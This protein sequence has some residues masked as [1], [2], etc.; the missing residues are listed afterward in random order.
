MTENERNPML[1]RLQKM[2]DEIE[3]W[4]LVVVLLLVVGAWIFS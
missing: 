3:I 4:M 2:G 1:A